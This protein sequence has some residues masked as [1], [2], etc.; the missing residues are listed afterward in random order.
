MRNR[1]NYY[2]TCKVTINHPDSRFSKVIES[3][4]RVKDVFDVKEASRIAK[5]KLVCSLDYII[6]IEIVKVE[7]ES[8]Y[9]G[10][11]DNN[12]E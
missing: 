1:Q 3:A 8:E 9:F 12:D 6:Q 2:V 10:R 7:T 4:I 5:D 11:E